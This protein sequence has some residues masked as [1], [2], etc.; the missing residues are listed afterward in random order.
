MTRLQL[1]FASVLVVACGTTT[2]SVVPEPV[3]VAAPGPNGPWPSVGYWGPHP[4]PEGYGGGFDY[5]E[6]PHSHP[7]TPDR[8]D[9]YAIND[10]WFVFVGDPFFYGYDGPMR[11]YAGPHVLRYP[12]GDVVCP[13]DGPHRHW[14]YS[15]VYVAQT[16]YVV[17]DGFWVYVGLWPLWWHHDHVVYLERHWP[18]H[19]HDHYGAY[20]PR[21]H[22]AMEAAPPRHQTSGHVKHEPGQPGVHD[23]PASQ[24]GRGA[25]PGLL[26]AYDENRKPRVDPDAPGR[27]GIYHSRDTDDAQGDRTPGATR[28]DPNGGREVPGGSSLPPAWN[29]GRR[30]LTPGS[31]GRAVPPGRGRGSSDTGLD[32]PVERGHLEPLDGGDGAGSGTRPT[33]VTPGGSDQPPAWN[34]NERP[35]G[36]RPTGSG[37]WGGQRGGDT[38]R[39][40]T[41]G[42]TSQPGATTRP[43]GHGTWQPPTGNA[44]SRTIDGGHGTVPRAETQDVTVPRKKHDDVPPR[45]NVDPKPASSWGGANRTPSSAVRPAAS[46]SDSDEQWRKSSTRPKSTPAPDRS[47]GSGSS[48]G[49]RPDGRRR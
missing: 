49:H 38:S 27:A 22:A 9:L 14:E 46:S 35:T 8:P 21:A 33:A 2:Y 15:T 48:G 1:L 13:L 31:D 4:V 16:D 32:L 29:D 25:H 24:G 6:G 18:R 44:G 42:G 17:V 28:G 41:G 30:D 11:W 19:Y 23:V 5:T 40:G 34:P 37:A 7:Y 20:V 3:A 45:Y 26:P 10:G 36:E 12:W 47:R 43:G 39:P